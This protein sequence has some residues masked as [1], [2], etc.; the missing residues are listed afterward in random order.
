[1][2]FLSRPDLEAEPGGP[3]GPRYQ[4]TGFAGFRAPSAHESVDPNVYCG[5]QEP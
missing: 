1:M 4:I 5:K 3:G 2:M